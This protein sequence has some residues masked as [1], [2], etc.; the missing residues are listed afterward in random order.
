MHSSKK[1][2]NISIFIR[3]DMFYPSVY[4]ALYTRQYCV[5]VRIYFSSVLRYYVGCN[6]SF[7]YVYHPL[8]FKLHCP[9]ILCSNFPSRRYRFSTC[10]SQ[11]IGPKKQ[12][13]DLILRKRQLAPS[14]ASKLFFSWSVLIISLIHSL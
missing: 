5:A 7:M 1:L 4:Y 10:T 6:I 3:V 9:V 8:H 11:G 14:V 13:N 12:W 2:Y